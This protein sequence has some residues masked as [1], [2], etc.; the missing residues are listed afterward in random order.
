MFLQ[1]DFVSVTM[2]SIS[3][4][5]MLFLVTCR[6]VS[7]PARVY[8]VNR[9][10]LTAISRKISSSPFQLCRCESLMVFCRRS[11][12]HSDVNLIT[13]LSWIVLCYDKKID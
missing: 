11:C 1:G 12:I 13:L 7:N 2:A 10:I 8:H 4:P 9:L 3:S 5:E 6:S